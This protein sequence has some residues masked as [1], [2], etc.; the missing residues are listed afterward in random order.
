MKNLI[1]NISAARDS[2][3]LIVYNCPELTR[4]S[5]LIID[6]KGNLRTNFFEKKEN[7]DSLS[8]SSRSLLLLATNLFNGFTCKKFDNDIYSLLV[9]LDSFEYMLALE[10]IDTRFKVKMF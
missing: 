6:Q 1:A 3:A 5:D 7:L 10:A 2:L 4:K 8:K 9:D